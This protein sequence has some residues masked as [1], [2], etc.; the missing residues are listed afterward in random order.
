MAAFLMNI[1]P[2]GAL[3]TLLGLA[4]VIL[5]VISLRAQGRRTAAIGLLAASLFVG[6][7]ASTF[8]LYLVGGA[9]GG[10]ETASLQMFA[11][12]VGTAASA[13]VPG[14]LS[15]AVGALVLGFHRD[16]RPL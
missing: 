4:G 7:L 1:G 15:A 11:R 16:H 9:V 6:L 12:G 2:I 13:S 3:S 10:A 5:A 14:A 8:G